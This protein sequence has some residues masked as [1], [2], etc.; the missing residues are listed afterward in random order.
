MRN[1]RQQVADK[2]REGQRSTPSSPWDCPLA[3]HV[4]CM[5]S[6][7]R[8]RR[9]DHF[10]SARAALSFILALSAARGRGGL[11]VDQPGMAT[12]RRVKRNGNML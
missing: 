6:R 11:N 5:V 1:F 12:H 3:D 9:G 7:R 2:Y 10:K 4:R 8:G